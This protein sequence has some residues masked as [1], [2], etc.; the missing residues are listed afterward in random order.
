VS[1]VLL[2]GGP[3]LAGAFLD[4]GEIDEV[5]LFLAP[6]LLGGRSARD[7]LEGEGVERIAEAIRALTLECERSA[8]D[9]LI[10]AR[11]REW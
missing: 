11:L 9:I 7:P 10:T 3:H 4:A 5:R 8:E 2:E 6:M 1:T